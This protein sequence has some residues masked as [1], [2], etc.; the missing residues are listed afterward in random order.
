[1]LRLHCGSFVEVRSW[2]L[3]VGRRVDEEVKHTARQQQCAG[4]TILMC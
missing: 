1:V 4:P 2:L 3:Q